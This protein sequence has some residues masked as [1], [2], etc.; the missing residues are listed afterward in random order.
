VLN[1]PE[2]LVPGEMTDVRG[3]T[4]DQI[5]DGDDAVPFPQKPVDQM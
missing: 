1:E 3:V 2:F 4:R 5:I